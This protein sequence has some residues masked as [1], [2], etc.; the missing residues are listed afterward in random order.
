VEADSPLPGLSQDALSIKP[1]ACR[2]AES[3]L[4]IPSPCETPSPIAL[5]PS[6]RRLLQTSRGRP[7]QP[8]VLLCPLPQARL[9][10]GATPAAPRG[11]SR[12][13]GGTPARAPATSGPQRSR[14]STEPLQHSPEVACMGRADSTALRPSVGAERH[15]ALPVNSSV[16]NDTI[17]SDAFSVKG[18]LVYFKE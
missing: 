13:D 12:F 11:A 2:D 7:V 18:N 15:V 1:G 9:L 10:Q 3:R 16:K 17:K 14:H 4:L 8:T 5:G 6:L